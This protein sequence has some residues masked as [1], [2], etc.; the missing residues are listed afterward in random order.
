MAMRASFP[1]G[2]AREDWAILR[3]L[4]DVL[5]QTAALR[6][7]CGAAPGA[8]QGA[9]ALAAYRPDRARRCGRCAKA[10][11]ARRQRR[12][13]AVPFQ[14]RRFLLHQSD[15]ALFGRDGGMFGA[16]AGPRAHDGGGVGSDGRVL[17]RLH[18]AVADHGGREP[19]AA[20]HPADRGRLYSLCR[21]QDLGGRA[22]PARPQRGRP[23]GA[24]PVVRRS[25]SSS[26]SRSRSSRRAPTRACS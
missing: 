16:C 6:F 7:A 4:S 9:S 26:C 12:A 17:V 1:P 10:C 13:G 15:R 2:D 18:L 20:H 25:A 11:C 14:R 24:V 21:P 5:G 23:V 22:D 3:A 19:A 8:V